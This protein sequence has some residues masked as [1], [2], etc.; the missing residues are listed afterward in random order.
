MSASSVPD[1]QV[2]TK[3]AALIDAALSQSTGLGKLNRMVIVYWTLSTYS[4]P[5]MNTFPLLCLLGKMGTGKSEALK[6]IRACSYRSSPMSLRNMTLPAIRDEFVQCCEGTAVIEEA[7]QA[8]RDSDST[9]ERLLSDRNQRDSAHSA[10]KQQTETGK[11]WETAKSEYFGAT[12]LHR[13]IPFNDAALDGRT[14]FVRFRA[15]HSRQY[16]EFVQDDLQIIQISELLRNFTF[17]PPIV[18]QPLGV[19]ARVFNSYRPLIGVAVLCGDTDFVEQ[20]LP[21]LHLHTSE[22]KEAQASEPDGLVLQAI[23]ASIFDDGPARFENIK[24]KTVTEW[25]WNNHRFS[26]L[27]RQV[28]PIARELGFKTKP[29]HGVTVIVT[30]PATLLAACSACDYTDEDIER[31]RTELLQT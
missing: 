15:D 21:Q 11:S 20:I 26:L 14:V 1:G 2:L 24:F 8:W 31:L 5:Y 7:D 30:T 9:F 10:H 18:E 29:S 17:Q 25:I 4:L 28:G 27:P 6:I 22:L 19:A 13:R 23:V 16:R 3:A 12:A